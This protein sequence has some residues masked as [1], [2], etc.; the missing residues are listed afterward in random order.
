MQARAVR[1]GDEY[2]IN[3]TKI[4]VGGNF[5]GDQY[6]VLAVT[7]PRGAVTGT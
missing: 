3:G 2:V 5:R 7:D 1:Q 4:F 6:F